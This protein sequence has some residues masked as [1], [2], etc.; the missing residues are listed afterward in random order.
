MSETLFSAF[1]GVITS[2]NVTE[3]SNA[4]KEKLEIYTSQ[5]VSELCIFDKL[6]LTQK[7]QP[8]KKY[9]AI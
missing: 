9:L 1:L 3:N 4:W 2:P 8:L 7:C 5:N 6:S